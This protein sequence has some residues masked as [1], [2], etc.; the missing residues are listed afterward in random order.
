MLKRTLIGATVLAVVLGAWWFDSSRP[1]SPAWALAGLGAVLVLGSLHEVL[2]MGGSQ[3][4]LAAVR[5]GRWKL[6][7][8]PS[9][10]LYDLEKDP[11]ERA[12][13]VNREISRKLRGMAILFQ[14][15][16]MLDARRPGLA[17]RAFR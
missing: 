11:G 3:G 7:L 12:P 1:G 6:H 16:M 15:E 5:S 13:V 14:Q 8:N 10:K 2:V 9:L 17:A 4:S